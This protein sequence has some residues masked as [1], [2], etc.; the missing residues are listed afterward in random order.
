MGVPVYKYGVYVRGRDVC[1]TRVRVLSVFVC[2]V[3]DAIPIPADL[4]YINKAIA[5]DLNNWNFL[6]DI[7]KSSG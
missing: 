3:L 1:L 6:D 4:A 2:A 7:V 5:G